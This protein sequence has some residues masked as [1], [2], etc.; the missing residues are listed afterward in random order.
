MTEIAGIRAR[1]EVKD[2]ADASRPIESL[3][4]RLKKY[5]YN[6]FTTNPI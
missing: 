6:S 2:S 3:L 5:K 4:T 1:I